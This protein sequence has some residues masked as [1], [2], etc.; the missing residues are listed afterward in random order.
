MV[1]YFEEL[2]TDL[3]TCT[4][5]MNIDTAMKISL[6]ASVS[7]G[8][9]LTAKDATNMDPVPVMKFLQALLLTLVIL[10]KGRCIQGTTKK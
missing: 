2:S 4:L 1:C 9:L 5:P 7:I 6:I 3:Q 8:K 10:R